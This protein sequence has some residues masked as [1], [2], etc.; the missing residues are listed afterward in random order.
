MR[1]I[2]ASCY[3]HATPHDRD[4]QSFS[5]EQTQSSASAPREN[6]QG[7]SIIKQ[8]PNKHQSDLLPKQRNNESSRQAQTPREQEIQRPREGGVQSEDRRTPTTA[9]RRHAVPAAADQ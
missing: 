7:R 2:F 6:A 5:E 3:N 1:M 9:D 4:T 8:A